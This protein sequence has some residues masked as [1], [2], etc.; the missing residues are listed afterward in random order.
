MLLRLRAKSQ[1]KISYQLLLRRPLNIFISWSGETSKAVATTLRSWLPDVFHN[2]I[3]PWMSDEDIAAGKP[4]SRELEDKLKDSNF[5]IVC[6]T[7]NN[8]FSP[9]LLY[10][11]GSLSKIVEQAYVIPL[12]I[13]LNISDIDRN[14]LNRFQ[15]VTMK[16]DGI[17]RLIKSINKALKGQKIEEVTLKKTFEKFWPDLN[18]MLLNIPEEKDHSYYWDNYDAKAL[19]DFACINQGELI[20]YMF[21]AGEFH[22]DLKTEFNR[23]TRNPDIIREKQERLINHLE[24]KFGD[25]V[26]KSF[27]EIHKM[28]DCR[29]IESPRICLKVNRGINRKLIVPAFRDVKVTYNS[30]CKVEENTGFEEIKENGRY[31]HCENIPEAA[32]SANYINPRLISKEVDKYELRCKPLS[33]QRR[34]NKDNEWVKCWRASKMVKGKTK[35][36]YSNCYKSTLIIPLTLWNNKLAKLF[37][38]KFNM[39][40]VERTIFGYLCFDHIETYYFYE[41]FDVNA[42]Y[43]FADLLSLYLLTYIIYIDQSKT[44]KKIQNHL[45]RHSRR[46]RA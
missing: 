27:A 40:N 2:A 33:S 6:V 24:Q 11:T 42:G 26:A 19:R 12:L 36:H 18:E 38:E 8:S 14:P 5:G 1:K 4:W 34:N 9:W 45:K 20:Q 44:Y 28:F 41:D 15:A 31:F 16:K 39:K 17:F 29:H 7:L 21:L 43:I 46:I 13:N 32:K 10:E 37:V 3:E 35:Q 25:A 30:S 23:K 22:K